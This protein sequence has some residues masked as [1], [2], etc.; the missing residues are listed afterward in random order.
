M[1]LSPLLLSRTLFILSL[2]DK[3]GK[4]LAHSCAKIEKQ[5][6]LKRYCRH[7]NSYFRFN[8]GFVRVFTKTVPSRSSN[9]NGR[10]CVLQFRAIAVHSRT[11]RLSQSKWC[12][13]AVKLLEIDMICQFKP[14]ARKKA[15]VKI[16]VT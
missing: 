3:R 13:L 7:I 16:H 11:G 15:G 2:I 9:P 1:A 10:G 12:L 5:L 4:P 8:M 6:R 14:A